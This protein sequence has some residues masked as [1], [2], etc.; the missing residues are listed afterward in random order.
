MLVFVDLVAGNFAG[1]DSLKN[2]VG[3]DEL[4]SLVGWLVGLVG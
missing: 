2:G 1:N 4:V 3:H